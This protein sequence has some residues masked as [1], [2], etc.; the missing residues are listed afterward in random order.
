ML[1][2]GMVTCRLWRSIRGTLLVRGH[3]VGPL[4]LCLSV[5]IRE[6]H[7]VRDCPDSARN[8][9]IKARGFH[10]EWCL[11]FG[12][13]TPARLFPLRA[14]L[15]ILLSLT[16]DKLPELGI[17]KGLFGCQH[18]VEWGH[19]LLAKELRSSKT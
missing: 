6:L 16:L 1:L 5:V 7:I 10:G 2:F 19:K 18:G 9:L 4:P 14:H 15:G 3:S 17:L 11:C 12:C 13:R 8:G